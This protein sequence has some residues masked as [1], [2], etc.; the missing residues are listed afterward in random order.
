MNDQGMMKLGEF[1]CA[2]RFYRAEEFGEA[3]LVESCSYHARLQ[4]VP[5]GWAVVPVK[6]TIEMHNAAALGNVYFKPQIQMDDDGYVRVESHAPDWSWAW[7]LMVEAA[8]S[9][10]HD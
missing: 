9:S 8:P 7:R 4:R 1:H 10:S 2:C 3:T 6:A 5:S